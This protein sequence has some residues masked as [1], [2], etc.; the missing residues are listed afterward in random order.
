MF[1][2]QPKIFISSTIC[3][4]P[5]ERTAAYNAVNKVGGFPIGMSLCLVPSIPQAQ[6]SFFF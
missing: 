6:P 1:I 3:D 5:N 2:T 4:L